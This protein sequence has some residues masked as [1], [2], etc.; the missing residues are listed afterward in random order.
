ML[1]DI[2]A[3]GNPEILCDARQL[4]TLEAAQFD[5]VYCSHNLEHYYKHDVAKVLNGFLHVLKLDGFA[6]IR[7]P[8]LKSVMKH[9]VATGLDVEDTLYIS[10]SG[11]ISVRDVI[12]GFGKEIESSGVDFYA[13]KTGFTPASLRVALVQAGFQRVFVIEGEGAFEVRAV[14]FK[15]EPSEQQRA[16]L[17]L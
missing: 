7:V 5:A 12:Y 1:L 10:P 11:P 3:A 4:S 14:A 9:V 13:H 8:N 6:E 15:R 2:D 16:T 17:R